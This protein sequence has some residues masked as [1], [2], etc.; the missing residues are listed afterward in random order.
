M[1]DHLIHIHQQ[2]KQREIGI[3]LQTFKSIATTPGIIRYEIEAYNES[4]FLANAS[5]LPIGLRIISDTNSLE[6]EYSLSG[7]EALQEFSGLVVIEMPDHFTDYL[8][9]EFIQIIRG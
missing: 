6:V 5:I 1:L 8:I 4:L 7:L 2:L 9:I 3:E